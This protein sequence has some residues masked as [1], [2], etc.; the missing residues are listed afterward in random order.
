MSLT[1]ADHRWTE[2]ESA[3][4]TVLAM[5]FLSTRRMARISR[6]VQSGRII[7]FLA[8]STVVIT[9]GAGVFAWVFTPKG[10]DSFGDA[11]WFTAQTVTTVGYGDVVPETAGGRLVGFV[12]MV[13]GVAAVSVITALVTSAF[14][15]FQRERVGGDVQRQQELLDALER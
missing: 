4:R 9:V 8:L 11:L 5:D 7:P 3:L 1:V 12:V 15:A 10:L 13:F 6:A 14:V 2:K